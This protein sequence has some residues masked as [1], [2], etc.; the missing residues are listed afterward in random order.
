MQKCLR[1]GGKDTDLDDVGRTERHCSFFEMMGNF[2]FGDYF[3]D[4]AV[5]YAW[6]FVTNVMRLDPE[7]ALGDGERGRSAAR[8]RR[9]RR[10]DRRLGARRHPA[11][12]DRAA[13]QGQLLAGG[14]DRALRPV[15]GDLLRPRRGVR[16][17]RPELRPGP[18]RP[19]HG[20]LQPRLHGVRPQ[21]GERARAAARTNV[22]TGMGVERT[23]C[24]L[25][26][27]DSNFDTDGFKRDHGLGR[28]QSGVAY[29]DSDVSSARTACSP[30]TC[31]RSLPGRRRRRALQRRTG[32]I[33]RRLFRR[34][35][36]QAQR[37]GLDRVY[38]LPAVVIEQMGDAYP[39]IRE[40]AG[41][42]ERV[43]KEEEAVP[44]DARAWTARARH[45]RGQAGDRR[46]RRVQ[47]RR[48][49][50]I[51][52]RADAGARG[53]AGQA[54]DVDGFRALMEEHRE[55][56]RAGGDATAQQIAAQ[57]VEPG[58]PVSEFVGYARTDVL[59]AVIDTAP[60]GETQQF[61]KLEKTPFYAA[62]GGQ[63]S[64]AGYLQVDGDS[65]RLKVVDVL[66]F[67][68]D[69]V[70]VVVNVYLLLL[71]ITSISLNL[72][73]EFASCIFKKIG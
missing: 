8:A 56:S 69:Q 17:R 5:D 15:L 65:A 49:V 67:G 28:A 35:I 31:A 54:V 16:V 11:R 60:Y 18:L 71:M 72:F 34:A 45:A 3:K 62:S 2:S 58:R 42:I 24:V 68:D 4:E 1:A 37:I 27:V 59:T 12:A 51:S 26:G 70:L 29:R 23:A 53:G 43:V 47:A 61:V 36:Q 20:D 19:L 25:Q 38:R 63:V 10:R 40:H 66:K 64:D 22:D 14:G 48:H 30:T 41:E 50:R 39:E 33:C 6:D 52:D 57:L 46:R 55:I 32:Y 7:R 44:R 13:R 73:I 21:A 9:G